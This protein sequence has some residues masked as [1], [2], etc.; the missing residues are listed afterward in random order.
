MSFHAVRAKNVKEGSGIFPTFVAIQ[1]LCGRR[2]FV[3]GRC[4]GCEVVTSGR[5]LRFLHSSRRR[6][7]SGVSTLYSLLS[8]TSNRDHSDLA[9]FKAAIALQGKRFIAAIDGLTQ[10]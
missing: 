2:G 7:F 4:V 3:G 6:E 10:R 8:G 9:C 5:L 1:E